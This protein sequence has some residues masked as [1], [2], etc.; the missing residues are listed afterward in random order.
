[1]N[2]FFAKNKKLVKNDVIFFVK[3]EKLGRKIFLTNLL[4]KIV[5]LSLYEISHKNEPLRN[6]F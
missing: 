3:N 5:N 1:M 2:I 4:R 6:D